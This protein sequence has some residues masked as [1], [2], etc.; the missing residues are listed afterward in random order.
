MRSGSEVSGT[1]LGAQLVEACPQLK[2][3]PWR[4]WEGANEAKR[5]REVGDLSRL[6]LHP[7]QWLLL[8][9]IQPV[10]TMGGTFPVSL[11]SLSTG[12]VFASP[13]AAQV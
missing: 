2:G 4:P 9:L 3:L 7:G 12:S 8:F 6:C 13:D 1:E 5:H 11:R 10:P